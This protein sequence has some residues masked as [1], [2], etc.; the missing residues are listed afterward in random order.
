MWKMLSVIWKIALRS[1]MYI[2]FQ[3]PT[4]PHIQ[5]AVTAVFKH[6]EHISRADIKVALN[7][8]SVELQSA[9]GA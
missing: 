7:T 1:K 6:K 3:G 5:M 9:E 2:Y 8:P 4:L